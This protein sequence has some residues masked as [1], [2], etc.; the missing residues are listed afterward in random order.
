MAIDKRVGTKIAPFA[1]KSKAN[2]TKFDPGPYIGIVKR[3]VDSTRKGR[4]QVYIPE[5]GGNNPEDETAWFT[6]SYASPFGGAT[7]PY[8]PANPNNAFTFTPQSYGFWM[9]P[10]DIGNEVLVTFVG[11]DPGRGF[12]F[13]CVNS[14]LS[15]YMTPGIASS[16]KVD[17]ATTPQSIAKFMGVDKNGKLGRY[18]VVEFNIDN[19]ASFNE[20]FYA[21]PKPLHLPQFMILV[22]QG[23]QNDTVRGTIGSS[24]QRETPSNVFGFSTPGRPY[25]IDPADDPSLLQ[26]IAEAKIDVGDIRPKARKGGHT[27]I[28]DDGNIKGED[29]LVR[30]R[31]AS[32][33]QIL[34]HDTEETVYIANANGGTW[35]E[36][37]KTGQVLIYA[38][39][40]MAIRTKGPMDFHSDTEINFNANT[41]IK[42][43]AGKG[44]IASTPGGVKVTGSQGISLDGMSISCKADVSFS[45]SAAIASVTG[46]GALTLKAAGKATLSGGMTTVNGGV[47]NLFG[48]VA[49]A[50]V[51][52]GATTASFGV[53]R[54]LGGS[55]IS[56]RGHGDASF[57]PDRGWEFNNNML[58]SIVRVLPTHEPY[59]PPTGRGGTADVIYEDTDASGNPIYATDAGP[60]VGPGRAQGA[61][62]GGKQAPASALIKQPEPA[63]GIGIL[64]QSQVKAYMAQIG[65]SE[66]AGSGD[67]NAVNTL[68]YSGK[69][70]MGAL[71]LID[72]GYVKPGTSNSGLAN[73]NNWT[74][75]DGIDSRESFLANPAIQES[76]AYDY[77][78]RNYN[79]LLSNGVI[80]TTSSATD[81]AG[82]L[83]VAHLLGSGGATNWYQ[84]Q[85][86]ADAY[87]TKGDTYYNLGRYSQQVLLANATT[88]TSTTTSTG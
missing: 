43:Y 24:A 10:P 15:Q 82:A 56:L 74:G 34:L 27:F 33:H 68:G 2:A 88:T 26:R 62:T 38:T 71:A 81:V 69:Y 53:S 73:P 67:Y 29:Q 31:T 70:Q 87:G 55:G 21:N 6:V 79:A 57:S 39:S 54:L 17:L 5:L 50:V 42:M 14:D 72:Q 7:R 47:V 35:I 77:T 46:V 48:G 28:L 58:Q 65:Y 41:A 19:E 36:L 49:G 8:G 61:T 78:A 51:G 59:K 37:T 23:L 64:N 86:G 22:K 30:L 63:G 66:S 9:I 3:T 32:G 16:D 18:P 12:W 4:L 52:G 40:G 45:A 1:D 20:T 25:G 76:A 60:A 84:G 83:A 13:A 80:T 11:G 85:G 44:I 75:K